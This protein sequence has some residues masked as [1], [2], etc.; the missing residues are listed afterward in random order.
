MKLAF[1]SNAYL[2]FSFNDAAKK[3]G[4]LGYQ[5]IEIMADVPHAWPAFMLEEQKQGIRDSLKSNNLAISN[6]NSFMMHAVNDSRQ[7]YWYPSWIEPD[8]HY[9][10]IRIDHTMRCL[11][12]AKELGAPCIT[13]EPGGPVEAGASW[14]A[15]L[16]LFVEMLKPVIEHAEKEG[17]LLLIEPEPGLLI[18]TADQ[19]L[20]FMGHI[21][22]PMVG[23]NFDIGHS[24]CVGDD[25]ASTIP[26]L[27]KYIKHYHLEDIANTRVHHHL[28]PGDGAIDFKAAIEAIKAIGYKEWV[29]IELYPYVE[30]PDQAAKLA[31]ERIAPLL[32]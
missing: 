29:T 6:I 14:N 17:V 25:P 10:Q 13:T 4:K 12:M 11:T 28:I 16:K 24:Y 19:F 26:K 18:E 9:R 21:K 15:G 2:R 31:R 20:E 23:C 8:K 22:S 27:A 7:R 30:D 32:A 5:G 3:I 1:S